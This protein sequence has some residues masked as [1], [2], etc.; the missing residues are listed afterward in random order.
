[1]KKV[2]V[3]LIVMAV[4]I[5]VYIASQ[6][7]REV[8]DRPT[9]ELVYVE[10]SSEVAS[11]NLVRAV[12]QEIMGY[13]CE[14]TAVSGAAM[15]QAV[16]TGNRDGMVAAWL[17]TTHGHYLE[18]NE[19]RLLDLG[20]NLDGTR[21]G[22]V[23][24]DYVD[25]RSIDELKVYA[26]DFDNEIIGIDPG[27]GIMSATQEAMEAYNLEDY[28]LVEGSDATMIAVLESAI[29]NE[30]SVVVTGWTPHWKFSRWD[31]RYLED[32]RDVYG[33]REQIHTVVRVGLP[34]EMPEVHT[35]LDQFYWEPEDMEELMN[36]NEETGEPYDN[37]VEWIKENPERVKQWLQGTGHAA[38][39]DALVEAQSCLM[40]KS[41]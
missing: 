36:R 6:A 8:D 3:P 38:N 32:P 20:P 22:L 4:L 31:L 15:W 12:L 33:G 16:A 2:L 26:E 29:R 1:M 14:I 37:A 10:W 35:F 18:A 34:Q 25:A 24:P 17:P 7:T 40:Q 11:T 13:N 9:V 30:Q 23:V 5:V 39:V 28:T 27:A 41:I 19:D 21:I